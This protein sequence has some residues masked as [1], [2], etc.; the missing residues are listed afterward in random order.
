MLRWILDTLYLS[1][2]YS[3]AYTQ[4][5]ICLNMI[6]KYSIIIYRTW[7]ASFSSSYRF[8]ISNYGDR[9]NHRILIQKTFFSERI[10]KVRFYGTRYKRILCIL[11]AIVNMHTRRKKKCD[12]KVR[13]SPKIIKQKRRTCIASRCQG[14]DIHII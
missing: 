14:T 2:W 6:K 11:T 1:R 8:T 5:W 10:Q 7:L 13:E 3:I 12:N 4:R 9:F